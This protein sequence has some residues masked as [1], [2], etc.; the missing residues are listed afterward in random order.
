MNISQK[1][2]E[3]ALVDVRKA[4]RLL[5]DYQQAVLDAAKY[6]GSRLGLDY[7]GGYPCF[8]NC[9]PRPGKIANSTW[10]WLNLVFYDFHFQ[11]KIADR[12]VNFLI[13]LFSDT[14][15]FVS[16]HLSPEKADV[17]TFCAGGVLTD[18][19]WLHLLHS[20]ERGARWFS[21][22]PGPGQTVSRNWD[23]TSSALPSQRSGGEM[24]SFFAHLR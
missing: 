1:E 4:Y 7:G 21:E 13:R 15:Y 24:L 3:K 2:I 6:I 10:D 17:S 5:H 12:D 9:S 23:R 22:R 16:S 8:G 18:Y 20:M 11:T 14:G 19:G